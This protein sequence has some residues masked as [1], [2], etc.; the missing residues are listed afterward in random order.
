MSTPGSPTSQTTPVATSPRRTTYYEPPRPSNLAGSR[1]PTSYSYPGLASPTAQSHDS[2]HA[3]PSSPAANYQHAPGDASHPN[4]PIKPTVTRAHSSSVSAP[5][6][7]HA[8]VAAAL[9]REES[10]GWWDEARRTKRWAWRWILLWITLLL[11]LVAVVAV[12]VTV[13]L[14]RHRETNGAASAGN[15]PQAPSP[16]TSSTLVTQNSSSSSSTA[17]SAVT[18]PDPT[19]APFPTP[20][21]YTSAPSLTSVVEQPTLTVTTDKSFTSGSLQITTSTNLPASGH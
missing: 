17:V 1:S 16:T 9:G 11:V 5:S 10:S 2:A 14:L 8:A 4:S 13:S 19:T 6:N 20:T 21:P 7:D 12:G 15:E 18:V 3:G